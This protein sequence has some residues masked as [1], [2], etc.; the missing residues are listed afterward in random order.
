[1]RR[2]LPALAA[3]TIVPAA[4]PAAAAP[5]SPAPARAFAGKTAAGTPITLDVTGKRAAVRSSV[6]MACIKTGGSSGTKA[7]IE[8]FQPT[9][10]FALT[11][12]D[13]KLSQQ[14]PS[15]VLGGRT[16]TINYH[17]E[18]V[19]KDRAISG[20]LSMNYSTSDYD[21]FTMSNTITVCDGSAAFTARRR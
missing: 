20:R 16:V 15:A 6:A 9:G 5:T 3:L 2:L 1:M 12:T 7:G 18:A 17:V 10:A 11:G 8:L 19:R 4:A 14:N 13:Q 21:V